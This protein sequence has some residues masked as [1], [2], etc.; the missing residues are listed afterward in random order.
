MEY[1]AGKQIRNVGSI[2]GNVM[3]G[4]PISDLIPVFQAGDCSLQ[5]SSLKGLAHENHQIVISIQVESLC[6]SSA[7]SDT[8]RSVRATFTIDIERFKKIIS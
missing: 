1:F 8:Q 7:E 6:S 2:G 3:T 5:V 4:C